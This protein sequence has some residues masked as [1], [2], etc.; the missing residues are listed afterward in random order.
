MIMFAKVRVCTY[1]VDWIVAKKIHM[2]TEDHGGIRLVYER[3]AP[4]M[5]AQTFQNWYR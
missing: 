3:A 2:S 4:V 1:S 5:Y